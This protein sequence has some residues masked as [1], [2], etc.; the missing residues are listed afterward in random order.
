MTYKWLRRHGRAS[1]SAASVASN[2]AAC[3]KRRGQARAQQACFSLQWKEISRRGGE[4]RGGR[5]GLEKDDLEWMFVCC[6][7]EV[8]IISTPLDTPHIL[9]LSAKLN[10]CVERHTGRTGAH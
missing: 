8:K 6:L 1:P 10:T 5:G 4:G 9:F 3:H 2:L 7:R